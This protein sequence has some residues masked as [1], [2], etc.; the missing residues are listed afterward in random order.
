MVFMKNW[1]LVLTFLIANAA[2]QA[3]EE[4]ELFPEK[5]FLEV[6]ITTNYGDVIVELN[7]NR[8]PIT[9]NN[10]LQY[11]KKAVYNNT[12]IHRVEKNFV[13][14]GGGYDKSLK[15]IDTCN[16]IFNESGNGLKNTR[17]TIAMARYEDPHSAT[18]QFYFNLNENPSLDPNSK[19]WGYTVFGEVIQGLEVLD[20]ISELATGY[21][22]E[23]DSTS[24]PMEP[25]IIN[26]VEI[27]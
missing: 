26:S 18:S 24:F 7:R 9:V 2:T 14:Q 12:I 21:H 17:G 3:C 15:A 13:V 20:K 6:K 11:V 1:C 22:K 27:L 8:A 19:N 23:F 10:F 5:L 16:S 4:G 25:I